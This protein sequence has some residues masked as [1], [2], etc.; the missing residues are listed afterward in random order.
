MQKERRLRSDIGR[1]DSI[2]NLQRLRKGTKGAFKI[3]HSTEHSHTVYSKYCQINLS[4]IILQTTDMIEHKEINL[5]RS[6][7]LFKRTAHKQRR[8]TL[9]HSYVKVAGHE[10]H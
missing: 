7:N 9:S 3:P 4:N 5:Q 1:T 2:Q 10:A 6:N 8:T